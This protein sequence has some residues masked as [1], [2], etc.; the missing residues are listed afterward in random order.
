MAI[1]Q[2]AATSATNTADATKSELIERAACAIVG[3][4]L[5]RPTLPPWIVPFIERKTG[6]IA[7]YVAIDSRVPMPA[8]HLE[9][10]D[11]I[12]AIAAKLK[13]KLTPM[14]MRR[15]QSSAH[16]QSNSLDGLPS[17]LQLLLERIENDIAATSS[18]KKK[19]SSKGIPLLSAGEIVASVSGDVYAAAICMGLWE[20]VRGPPPARYSTD[21][22]AAIEALWHAAGAPHDARRKWSDVIP[23]AKGFQVIIQET[24]DYARTVA[25]IFPT[26]PEACFL[27]SADS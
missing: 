16:K 10:L 20:F 7:T 2:M 26:D 14:V 12:K 5:G 9:N 19:G 24:R 21:L 4:P 18:A 11:E 3:C 1:T 22:H 8:D 6:D 27:A 17:A 23:K 13:R 25:L 15:L